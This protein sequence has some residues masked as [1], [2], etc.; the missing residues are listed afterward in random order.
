MKVKPIVKAFAKFIPTR[1]FN[2]LL[3]ELK[4]F[5]KKHSID[6]ICALQNCVSMLNMHN[7]LIKIFF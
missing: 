7:I 4:G 5:V 6:I 2:F 3:V 1:E